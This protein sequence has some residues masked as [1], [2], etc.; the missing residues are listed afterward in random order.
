MLNKTYTGIGRL[1]I[2]LIMIGM[3][4]H[5]AEA[6]DASNESNEQKSTKKLRALIIDGQNNH[7]AWPATTMMMKGYL[8]S[9]GRFTVDIARTKFT[10]R[11]EKLVEEHALDDGKEYE[12]LKQPKADPDFKP[13]FS[14]YDVVVSNFG[15][16][17]AE[18]PKETKEGLVK[19]VKNG[20]GFVVVH[21]ADN[22]FGDWQEFNEIIGLG[23]WG[24]RT[25][26]NGPYVYFDKDEKLTRNES[27]GR[28]GSHGPQHEYQIVTR[29]PGHAIMK[30]LPSSW[31]HAK[32][33][34][35]DKL[36]GPAENMKIL[37]TAYSAKKFRGTERHEPIVMTIDYGKGR[38]F[39]TPMG[40][41]GYSMECVGYRTVFVRGTEWAATGKVT[42][43]DV[44][45]D[46]PTRDKS[47]SRKFEFKKK[48]E[49]AE[50]K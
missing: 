41:A 25:Q 27:E 32:D 16:N 26:Q 38:C 24:G 20:G 48:A 46:F 4:V 1:L 17:A 21:A 47:S 29:D 45:K 9:S 39:H 7:R 10:W 2:V 43:T 8:E 18:W 34:L 49:K 15:N 5:V 33:E 3:S 40:H 36:R 19:F 35:Y 22:S 6:Q 50:A 28:V 42:L 12:D 44:P 14:K 30:G 31:L 13:E 23:G 37:A 11:G